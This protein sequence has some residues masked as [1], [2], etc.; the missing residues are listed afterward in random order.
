MHEQQPQIRHRPA[1]SY[2]AIR[3]TV[4]MQGLPSAIDRGFP[5]LFGWLASQSVGLSGPPF[6]RYLRV[7]MD[8][9]L[10]IELAAP[11]DIEPPAAGRIRPGMLPAGRYVTLLHVGPYDGLVNANAALR[12]W[13]QERGILWQI[14]DASIWGGRI[15]RYLT[16]P[17]QEPDPSAWKTEVAYLI[18]DD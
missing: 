17:S 13:A 8:A 6:I 15:E 7:D 3:E 11:V 4:T 12:R 2:A 16:D 10:T 9:E 1:Q 18:A 14:D 5:E